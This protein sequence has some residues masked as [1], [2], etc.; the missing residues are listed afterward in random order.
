MAHFMGADR[1]ARVDAVPRLGFTEN[2]GGKAAGTALFV[3]KT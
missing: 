1:V 3:E 2:L